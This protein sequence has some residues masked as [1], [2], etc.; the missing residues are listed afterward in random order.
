MRNYYLQG[1]RHL[2]LPPWLTPLPLLLLLFTIAIVPSAIAQG[3]EKGPGEIVICPAGEKDEHTKVLPD[4]L[5]SVSEMHS[6]R[7]LATQTATFEVTFGPGAQ[8]NPGAQAAFLFALDIWSSEIVSDVPIKVFADFANLGPGVLAAA[9]PSFSV[10]N[11]SPDAL[12]DIFYPAALANAIAGE[13][14]F[15]DDP[16]DLEVS[17][18]NGINWYFGLDT[19]TP[20]GQFNFATVALHEIGH[21]LGFTAIRGV[22]FGQGTLRSNGSYSIY[23]EFVEL[24]DGTPITSLADPSAALANALTG[25][26]IFQAGMNT[27]EELNGNPAE[28]FA[29]SVFQGGSSYAHWDEGTFPAGNPN[30]LMTPQVGSAESIFNIGDITRGLFQD[31][32]WQINSLGAPSLAVSPQEITLE[33][34]VGASQEVVLDL[35]NISDTL[36]SFTVSEDPEQ[37]WLSV[38]PSAGSL[39]AGENT[40]LAVS[41]SAAVLPKG[42]YETTLLISDGDTL[43]PT[44]SV[45]VMLTVLDGTEA[46][47][48]EVVP[49]SLFETLALLETST[50]Q[51]EITNAGDD[52]LVYSVMVDDLSGST[53]AANV[54][55]TNEALTRG[56]RSLSVSQNNNGNEDSRLVTTSGSVNQIAAPLYTTDFEGF[57]LGELDGQMGWVTQLAANWVI[58]N[59]NPFE[60]TRHIRAT[61]DGSNGSPFN[62]LALSPVVEPGPAPFSYASAVMQISGSGGVTWEFIPQSTSEALVNTRVRFNPDGSISVLDGE[63]SAFVPTGAVVPSGYFTI[64]VVVDKEN[65]NMRVLLDGNLI[66]S[67]T[68]FAPDIE[69]VVLFSPMEAV[70]SILDVDNLDIVD[71]DPESFFISVNTMGGTLAPGETD[72]VD[73]FFDAR[74]VDSTGEYTADIVI[75]SNDSDEPEVRVPATLNVVLPPDIEVAPDSIAVSIDVQTDDPPTATRTITVTNNGEQTLT[76][77]A[78]TGATVE[79]PADLLTDPLAGLDMARYGYGNTSNQPESSV[80]AGARASGGATDGIM[81]LPSQGQDNAEFADSIFYDTGISFPDDFSGLQTTAYTSATRFEVP[82]GGFT[83]TAVRNAY[84]TEAVA[85]PTTILEIRQGGATPD[86]GTLLLTQTINTA[87]EEGIFLLTELEQSFAF[88]E[89][90]VFWIIHKYPDGV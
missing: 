27:V 1:G 80:P 67:G 29:P 41:V 17:L 51:V 46:P 44:L 77:T 84:R 88:D 62:N 2:S 53:F 7:V 56:F 25:G 4:G 47:E 38:S 89:G 22:S 31:M 59:T 61:S 76:F 52:D 40:D 73:V 39:T 64:A 60:G 35:S 75:S 83:L 6:R 69:Q 45:P 78:S 43:T 15:P 63:V 58:A 21:G 70:G 49:D 5:K 28:L 19:N 54:A 11:F 65:L 81:P 37:A 82:A 30:S 13:D 18:G 90:D 74:L 55:R 68:A 32:G 3:T 23:S 66:F 36:L 10:R 24:G 8:A 34:L 57:A 33:L 16:F 79:E 71:G 9:G 20:A 50:R 42:V 87:S 86:Q 12:P 48:I 85:N 26:D 72:I 14:L